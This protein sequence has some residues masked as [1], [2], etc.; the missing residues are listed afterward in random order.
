M[1]LS[2]LATGARGVVGTMSLLYGH[3]NTPI[4][5]PTTPCTTGAVPVKYVTITGYRDGVYVCLYIC[6][7]RST[8]SAAQNARIEDLLELR[9]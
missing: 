8:Q 1:L 5:P 7:K 4:A 9:N 6:K 2:A 3:C